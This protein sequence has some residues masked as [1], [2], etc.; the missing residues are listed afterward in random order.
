MLALG[1]ITTHLCSRFPFLVF[2]KHVLFIIYHFRNWNRKLVGIIRI[3]APDVRPLQDRNNTQNDHSWFLLSERGKTSAWQDLKMEQLWL[4]KAQAQPAGPVV[5][6]EWLK[7]ENEHQT[8]RARPARRG[9]QFPA[10]Q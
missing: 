3:Y 8:S 10:F 2:H 9:E 7:E 4:R 5:C 1:A 6:A